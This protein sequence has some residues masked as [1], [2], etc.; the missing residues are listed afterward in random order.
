MFIILKKIIV[1]V[2]IASVF[3]TMS[4][5]FAPLGV[6]AYEV[7]AEDVINDAQTVGVFGEPYRGL[8]YRF[9]VSMQGKYTPEAVAERTSSVVFTKDL[10]VEIYDKNGN[11]HYEGYCWF[12]YDAENGAVYF[13]DQTTWKW[14][15][16]YDSD[17]KWKIRNGDTFVNAADSDGCFSMSMG[18]SMLPKIGAFFIDTYDY[19]YFMNDFTEEVFLSDIYIGDKTAVDVNCPI[20]KDDYVAEPFVFDGYGLSYKEYDSFDIVEFSRSSANSCPY[21]HFGYHLDLLFSNNGEMYETIRVSDNSSIIVPEAPDPINEHYTFLCWQDRAGQTYYPGY[22]VDARGLT[23]YEFEAVW[24][25]DGLLNLIVKDYTFEEDYVFEVQIGGSITLPILEDG[26]YEF[27]GY[28][29]NK[30]LVGNP[31]YYGGETITVT[32]NITLYASWR[33]LPYLTFKFFDSFTGYSEIIDVIADIG[34]LKM[35][36]MIEERSG[37]NFIAWTDGV[38]EF[39]AGSSYPIVAFNSYD[40]RAVWKE[41]ETAQEGERNFIAAFFFDTFDGLKDALQPVLEFEIPLVNISLGDIVTF[42]FFA[43]IL[44]L[45]VVIVSKVLGK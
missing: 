4:M 10:F 41:A 38:S 27:V 24:A 26:L 11:F 30:S 13:C 21:I 37:Y 29:D 19:I 1:V 42:V 28:Y 16:K 7:D 17:K 15:A 20:V 23:E 2:L 6:S 43:L 14:V 3:L 8:R 45:V 40:L 36:L 12:G 35:P 44:W 22:L 25:Y 33:K 9:D 39:K 18:G 34:E 5:M 32:E 31:L